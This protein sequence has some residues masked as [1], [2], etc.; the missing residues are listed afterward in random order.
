M[1]EI[2]GIPLFDKSISD[3]VQII[4]DN[5]DPQK[6]HNFC[7]SATGAH[8]LIHSKKNLKFKEILSSFYINLPDGMPSVWVGRYKGSH[9][10]ERCYGPDFFEMA[11]NRSNGKIKHFLCG[12]KGDVA[13]K[14]EK[15]CVHD[16]KAN[17]VGTYSP[18][19]VSIEQYNY[20]QI[21]QMINKLGANVVWIGLST[22]KQE[23]FA[24][25]LAKHTHVNFVCCVGAAFD[26]HI[27]NVRQ[28][29]YWVQSIGMEWFFRLIVEP[30]RL[31]RR[32]F[33][34]VPLFIYYNFA[35]LIKKGFDK[36]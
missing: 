7:V 21:G 4:L 29:P 3:A 18:P 5:S 16:F 1:V 14:L 2:L 12:G 13:K 27:G 36:K 15:V 24:Y 23:E 25:N 10:M 22:P 19:F 28:A 11:M 9:T 35:E 32:Y 34:I 31:W 20:K 26:F 8:G 6:L 33:E 30:K 17:V